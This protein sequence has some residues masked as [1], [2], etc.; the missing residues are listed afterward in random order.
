MLWYPNSSPSDG[1]DIVDQ[2]TAYPEPEDTVILVKGDNPEKLIINDSCSDIITNG[3]ATVLNLTSHAG[4]ALGFFQSTKWVGTGSVYFTV[5]IVNNDASTSNKSKNGGETAPL[6]ALDKRTW[7]LVSTVH[8]D[9]H[10]YVLDVDLSRLEEHNR[11]WLVRHN[12]KSQAGE[13]HGQA[14]KFNNDGAKA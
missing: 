4:M 9:G 6:W 1:M 11:T 13:I 8:D 12:S 2:T 3:D 10:E 7:V 5:A 14:F